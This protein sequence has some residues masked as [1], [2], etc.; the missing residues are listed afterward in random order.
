MTY[1]KSGTVVFSIPPLVSG[2]SYVGPTGSDDASDRC[3]CNTVVYS[4]MSACD[5]CQFD[6]SVWF[7]YVFLFS[8]SFATFA[9][10]S[11]TIHVGAA[12][13]GGRM[14]MI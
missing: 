9:F 7:T 2:D 10:I 14:V 3:K 1:S 11:P 4:L 12:I 8:F 6:D 13:I 5:A